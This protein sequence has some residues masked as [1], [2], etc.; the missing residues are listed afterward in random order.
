M[1]IFREALGDISIYEEAPS[2]Q[3]LDRRTIS[4]LLTDVCA[5]EFDGEA[6]RG[7]PIKTGLYLVI[8]LVRKDLVVKLVA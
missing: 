3:S 5:A 8:W 4:E 1:D 6:K 2:N 7:F